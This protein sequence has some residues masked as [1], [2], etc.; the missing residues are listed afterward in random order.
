M[1]VEYPMKRDSIFW[2]VVLVLFGVLFLL[3]NAGFITNVFALFWPLILILV[4]GWIVLGVFWKPGL[5]SVE[6]FSVPLGAAKSVRYRF[7]HGAAQIHITGGAPEGQAIVGSSAVGMN[8][9]S[10]SDG[11]RLEVKVD[12]GPS[13]LPFIGPSGGEWRYQ[14]TREVPVSLILEAGAS[15]FD[16]DLVD[17]MASEIALKV[18][19]STANVTLPAQGVSRLEI[20]GG[21]ASFNV[22]VPEG[23]A[24]RINSVEGFTS[25][26]IDTNRFPQLESRVY[27]SPDFDTS[28]NRADIRLRAG[29]GSL[30]VK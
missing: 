12:T 9:H 28:P 4:G 15:S 24:A 6:T 8:F 10:H 21:A 7:S 11:D 30:T 22:R 17:S 14:I 23:T 2:G 5:D 20:E 25:L 1:E 18:G 3:Q 19:A 26:N 27:Q 16:I 29:V 13:F